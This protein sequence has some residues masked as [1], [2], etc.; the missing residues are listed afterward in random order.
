MSSPTYRSGNSSGRAAV[1]STHGAGRAA[2]PQYDNY[3]PGP[4]PR[5]LY[6]SIPQS[7][8]SPDLGNTKA[9]INAAFAWGGLPLAVQ[10]VEGYTGVHVDHTV[11]V[12][13]GGFKEVTDAL[14]GVD[15][16]ID[17]SITSIHQ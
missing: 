10:T 16:N 12:D 1:P 2:G 4:P 15:L 17:Q 7:P 5:D 13:F 6:V 8:T 3:P 9:K 14:G 11:L